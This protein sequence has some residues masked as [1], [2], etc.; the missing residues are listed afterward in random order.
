[1]PRGKYDR[2]EIVVRK[3]DKVMQADD[4]QQ[5]DIQGKLAIDMYLKEGMSA[6]EAIRV[7]FDKDFDETNASKYFLRMLDDTMLRA[8]YE[9][10][11]AELRERGE[12]KNLW[13]RELAVNTLTKLISK[14]ETELY[15]EEKP[16]NMTRVTAIISAVKELNMMSGFITEKHQVMQAVVNFSGDDRMLP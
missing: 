4:V 12:E 15:D 8:Y 9:A 6:R 1:M 3:Q 7:A 13:T 10:N 11:V 5:L 14:A 16:L 2:D